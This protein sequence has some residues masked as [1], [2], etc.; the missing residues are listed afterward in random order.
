M[1]R[2]ASRCETIIDL[3]DHCLAEYDVLASSSR[4]A[5]HRSTPRQRVLR[6]SHYVVNP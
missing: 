4:P 6:P 2:S 1:R 3:I 5:P